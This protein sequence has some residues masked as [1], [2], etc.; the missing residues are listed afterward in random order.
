MES[1]T[2]AFSGNNAQSGNTDQTT[3][4]S[5]GGIGDSINSAL[6][7]GQSSEKNEDYLD[8][9]CA[10]RLV[11]CWLSRSNRVLPTASMLFSSTASAKALR[12]TRTR[13]SSSRMS[14]SLMLSE[15]EIRSDH[16][17]VHS[18]KMNAG[19]QYKNFTGS[20]VPIADK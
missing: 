17:Y 1:I 18:L 8:K 4:S 2:N 7:G 11:E 19:R 20:D 5:G 12:T 15:G 9:G 3:S 6:G 16:T 13:P 10:F 14:R